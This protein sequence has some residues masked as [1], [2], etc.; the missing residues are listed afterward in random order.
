MSVAQPA[1][2][3][4]CLP[5]RTMS[6]WPLNPLPAGA[7]DCH[8]HVF[9]Q[10]AP[11]AP[12]RSYTPRLA[13]LADWME[14]A[15]SARIERGV[16]VQPSVYG[17]DNSVLLTALKARPDR[18]RG[19]V[20]LEST[21]SDTELERLNGQGVRGIRI[22]TRN[23]GGLSFET[24]Q[25]FAR[26]IGSLGWVLQFQMRPEQLTALTEVASS[27]NVPLVLDHFGFA[28]PARGTEAITD[29]QR[30]LDTGRSYVKLSAPYR[31]GGMAGVDAIAAALVR[32]HPE[33]LLWG[34][35]W[36][37]TELFDEVPHDADLIDQTQS[38]LPDDTV[39]QRI[40]IDTPMSLFFN[41]NGA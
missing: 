38:W 30:L 7:I 13:T 26:R 41:D 27:L 32:S 6:R 34:S 9:A 2:A 28:D 5:P 36:P 33:R 22:N 3:P 4:L 24:T 20:V 29:L 40:F 12:V 21:V 39:R 31:I 17:F 1:D 19:I 23:L 37:H 25:E 35:D 15:R 10:D 18:L 14:F 11:L 16:L 8:F